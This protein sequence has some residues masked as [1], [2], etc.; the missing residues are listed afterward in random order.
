MIILSQ[1]LIACRVATAWPYPGRSTCP[2]GKRN[3]QKTFTHKQEQ[4]FVEASD[5][6]KN[7][8]NQTLRGASEWGDKIFYG[9][10]RLGRDILHVEAAS[11]LECLCL[12]DPKRCRA[13]PLFLVQEPT[14]VEAA[15]RTR[16]QTPRARDGEVSRYFVLVSFGPAE[17]RRLMYIPCTIP[18]TFPRLLLLWLLQIEKQN[19]HS[20]MRRQHAPMLAPGVSCRS[21]RTPRD[22]SSPRDPT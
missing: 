14:P 15:G 20:D 13:F 7:D 12:L 5:S 17:T 11:I 9:L 19:G 4:G 1:P 18:K 21:G 16:I 8:P 10:G 22:Q 3:E 2:K 6:S